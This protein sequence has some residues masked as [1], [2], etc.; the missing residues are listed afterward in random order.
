MTDAEFR[1]N[2]TQST[3]D[4]RAA[5]QPFREPMR[6]TLIRTVGIA[7]IAGG[8]LARRWGGLAHWPLATAVM[9]WPSLGGHFVELWFLNWLRPRLAGTRG[10]HLAT[11]LA[12]WF[13][14]GVALVLCMRLTLAALDAQRNA[15]WPA[16]W[17]AGLALVGIEVVVHG[18]L[19]LRG[20]PSAFNGQG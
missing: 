20:R 1:G 2:S 16:W 10:V 15:H 4:Q 9:L 14:G 18:A 12:V 6:V 8:V 19:L 17:T 11:R 3:A 5:W 7:L 13:V